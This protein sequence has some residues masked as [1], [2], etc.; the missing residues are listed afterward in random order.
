MLNALL[1]LF[2]L[3]SIARAFPLSFLWGFGQEPAVHSYAV[4]APK[5]ELGWVDPR[6][7]GGQFIDFTTPRFGEPLNIIISNLSDPYILTEEECLGL[8][9][10]HVH[11]ADL[12][13]G[14]GR[15]SEHILARQHYFPRWGTCWESLIG[16]NHFRAWKQN[17]TLADTGAWFLAASKEYDS[18]K[19]HMIV[20]NG[21]NIGRD[22][23]VA[24]AYAGS[25]WKGMSW[26]AEIEWRE[27]LLEPGY[28]GINHAIAQDGRIAVLT[29]YR[30]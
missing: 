2:F 6:V 14:D 11:K 13:D 5:D 25:S 3:F 27:G 4:A 7:L 21:Y 23:L 26:V 22:M 1:S 8:H 18:I 24:N 15:K 17:G 12:G 9:Y 16:G 29:V 10:G 30:V 20:P 28:K 19:N